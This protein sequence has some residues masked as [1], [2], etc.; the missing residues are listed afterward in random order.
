MKPS[1]LIYIALTLLVL[2][3]IAT[4]W[5]GNKLLASREEILELERVISEKNEV[6]KKKEI[7]YEELTIKYEECE[8]ILLQM[9]KEQFQEKIELISP[10]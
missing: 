2:S 1:I 9:A 4:L 5:L 3:S 6:I 7:E 8:S 10:N